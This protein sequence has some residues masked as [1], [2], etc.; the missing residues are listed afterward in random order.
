[1]FRIQN[2]S[3]ANH[4][5]LERGNGTQGVNSNSLDDRTWDRVRGKESHRNKDREM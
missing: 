2:S 4:F 1:M 3:T 5:P